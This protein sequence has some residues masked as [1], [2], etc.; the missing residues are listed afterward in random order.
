MPDGVVRIL[1]F[2]EAF[3]ADVASGDARLWE[4]LMARICDRSH[5]MH[6]H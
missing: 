5:N 6:L 1:G 4:G 2:F 3:D